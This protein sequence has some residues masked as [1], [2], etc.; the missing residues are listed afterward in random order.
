MVLIHGWNCNGR[1]WKFQIP[2]L[3]TRHR[4]IVLDLAG[5]GRS[6]MGR[7][8]YTMESF[9]QD[10]LAVVRAVGPP[11]VILVGHSMGGSVAAEAARLM[12]ERVEGIIGIDTLENVEA[13]MTIT[14]RDEML[15]PLKADFPSGCRSFVQAMISPNTDS[16]MAQWIMDDISSAPP[17]VAVNSITHYFNQYIDGSAARVFDDLSIPVV[18]VRGDRW[19][20]DYEAN[21]RRMA[22][23][24][25]ITIRGADHFLMLTRPEE[26][27]HA[28]KKAIK[29]IRAH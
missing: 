25:T 19:P 17:W 26:C 14:A 27:N 2:Y 8:E 23:F 5:H 18:V 4:V 10:V 20:V 11:R 15:A 12:P 6:G 16:E 7:R 13:P 24:D 9:G 3:S 21:R 29:K 1:Y 22:F 28:L